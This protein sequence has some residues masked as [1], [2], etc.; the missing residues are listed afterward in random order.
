MS[1]CRRCAST[2]KRSVLASS[3]SRYSKTRV[4]VSRS[5]LARTLRPDRNGASTRRSPHP[6]HTPRA[7]GSWRRRTTH[8]DGRMAAPDGGAAQPSIFYSLFYS[9]GW[10]S[11]VLLGLRLYPI[12]KK[13]LLTG[14]T[15]YGIGCNVT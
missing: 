1:A 5:T 9:T 15:C 10:Y 11:E 6:G 13:D 7:R 4:A 14:T 8:G 12:F 2:S 3:S